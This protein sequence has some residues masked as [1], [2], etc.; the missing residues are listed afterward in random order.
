MPKPY[1]REFRDDV[2]RV[3]RGR[4]SGQSVQRGDLTH[5]CSRMYSRH[6]NKD[7]VRE[8]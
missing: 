7:Y 3:A 2:V 6:R 1:P 8:F 5:L 4:E